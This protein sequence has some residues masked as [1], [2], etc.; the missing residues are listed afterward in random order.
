MT[1]NNNTK[2]FLDNS[3]EKN[4]IEELD[5]DNKDINVEDENDNKTN[6]NSHNVGSLFNDFN[7]VDN[8]LNSSEKIVEDTN[9]DSKDNLAPYVVN[10]NLTDNLNYNLDNQSVTNSTNDSF[11]MNEINTSNI[12]SNEKNNDNENNNQS[13]NLNDASENNSLDS[14]NY[15]KDSNT[16][17]NKK[18]FY[19]SY[20]SRFA[21][22]LAFI[23]ILL[24][25]SLY[26][27][28]EAFNI[29]KR[30]TVNYT[31]IGN[32]NYS[33]IYNKTDDYANNNMS[34]NM[35]YISSLINKIKINYD[36][37]I[38]FSN[39]INYNLKYSVKAL[40]TI[41]DPD[42]DTQILKQDED[43]LVKDTK[44]S[45]SNNI[46]SFST[47]TNID[48]NKYNQYVINYKNN[49]SISANANLQVI[50]F[51][52]DKKGSHQVS[53]VTIP[54][55]EQ[56]ISISKDSLNTTKSIVEKENSWTAYNSVC[57]FLSIA[58][59]I[60]C[61]I[62]IIRLIKLILNSNKRS[63]YEEK[64]NSILRNYDRV[65]VSAKESYNV[66]GRTIVK[67]YTFD[68]LLDAR[69]TLGKPIIYYKVNNVKS[70]FYVED[71]YKVY[72]YTLKEADFKD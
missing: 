54:L 40:L 55:G 24:G 53:S 8:K 34:E 30:T 20:E 19:I 26:L 46:L 33:V 68:E 59:I 35:K 39:N 32:A 63:K 10:S 27:V 44:V 48:Y 52:T 45:T 7:S 13:N 17:A 43:T 70:E 65:I 66:D 16:I 69:D 58:L 57:A 42:D 3:K 23:F 11:N 36:Y 37:N 31:E 61:I 4:D 47:D 18:Q 38:K 67:V 50:L 6:S 64:L 12:L 15:V 2:N 9:I 62:L 25:S 29:G 49:Y 60:L 22:L 71:E 51:V 56:T 1:E 72:K 41:T 14:F 28:F 21:L 5:F